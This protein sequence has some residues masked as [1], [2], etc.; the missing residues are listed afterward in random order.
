MTSPAKPAA[1]RSQGEFAALAAIAKARKEN[2]RTMFPNA[3]LIAYSP[4]ST[5][6]NFFVADVGLPGRMTRIESSRSRARDRD[7]SVTPLVR[8]SPLGQSFWLS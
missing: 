4:T 5:V 3:Y 6:L 1:P 7:Y 2:L 8:A